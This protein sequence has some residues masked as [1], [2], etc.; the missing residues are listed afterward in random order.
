MAKIEKIEGTFFVTPRTNKNL[1]IQYLKTLRGY[2]L[3]IVYPNVLNF[4][5]LDFLCWEVH[6]IETPKCLPIIITCNSNF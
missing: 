3:P 1:E 6:T 4:N 5:Y 2:T